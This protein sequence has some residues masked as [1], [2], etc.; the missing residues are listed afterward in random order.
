MPSSTHTNPRRPSF[1]S[2]STSPGS[3]RFSFSESGSRSSRGLFASGA[4]RGRRSSL[5]SDRWRF[6]WEAFSAIRGIVPMRSSSSRRA[7]PSTSRSQVT[8]RNRVL[9]LKVADHRLLAERPMAIGNEPFQLIGPSSGR[10]S[11][12]CGRSR[13]PGPPSLIIRKRFPSTMRGYGRP[14]PGQSS[15]PSCNPVLE[16]VRASFSGFLRDEQRLEAAPQ[17]LVRHFVMELHFRPLDERPELL[18]TAIGAR[19]LHFGELAVRVFP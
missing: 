16:F 7:T 14:P 15:Q 3:S 12:A 8:G 5:S 11:V 4:T 18:R 1:S 17:K 13:R 9:I 6:W 10:G 2:P 19:L